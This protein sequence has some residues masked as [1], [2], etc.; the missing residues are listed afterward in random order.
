VPQGGHHGFD[1][2]RRSRFRRSHAVPRGDLRPTDDP[3]ALADRAARRLVYTGLVAVLLLG[4]ANVRAPSDNL[5]R[6]VANPK[7]VSGHAQLRTAIESLHGF[8]TNALVIVAAL[9]ALAA[10]LHHFRLKDEVLRR[11]LE[12]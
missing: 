4:I 10:L 12:R 5:F 7:R 1:A 11:M 3:L 6:L 2:N 8:L 9:H